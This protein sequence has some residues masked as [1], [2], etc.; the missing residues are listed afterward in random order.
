VAVSE[1]LLSSLLLKQYSNVIAGTNDIGRAHLVMEVASGTNL[2]W[3]PAPRVEMQPSWLSALVTEG[4]VA[5][6]A[7]VWASGL[8]LAQMGTVE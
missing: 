6:V 8:S 1:L 4:V 5:V 7:A 2:S 3:V